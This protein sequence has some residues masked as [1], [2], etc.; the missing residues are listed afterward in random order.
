MLY[1]FVAT[2][3]PENCPALN[4]KYRERT[5]AWFEKIEDLY[6]KYGIKPIGFWNDHPGHTV[7]SIYDA[8]SQEANVALMME[9]IMH[10]MLEFQTFRVFPVFTGEEIYKLIKQA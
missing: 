2:H 5:L 7:Y 10:A 9:P 8:P 6:K 1:M 3:S 4:P